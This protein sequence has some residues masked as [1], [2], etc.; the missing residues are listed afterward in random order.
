MSS[1]SRQKTNLRVDFPDQDL[2][3]RIHCH[4]NSVMH[5]QETLQVERPQISIEVR[6]GCVAISGI[7]TNDQERDLV[8]NACRRV[9]GVLQLND[10][11]LKS[12]LPSNSTAAGRATTSLARIRPSDS[13]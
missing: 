8:L 2:Q 7:V 3:Q 5:R 12:S 13:N 10:Q 6:D 11:A 1:S 9:A 4:L